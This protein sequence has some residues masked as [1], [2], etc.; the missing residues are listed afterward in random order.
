MKVILFFIWGFTVVRQVPHT[1]GVI[2]HALD[3]SI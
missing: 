1:I 3:P 2:G